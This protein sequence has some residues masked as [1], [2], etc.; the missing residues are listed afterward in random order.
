MSRIKLRNGLQANLPNS[1]MLLGEPLVTT[2]R[3]T[4]HVA[5]SPTVR[6]PIVPA[7]EQ[8]ETLPAVDGAADLLLIHDA[9][10]TGQK[11]KKITLNAF[12]TALNIPVSATDEK[13]SVVS[14][15]AAGY[16]WGTDGSDGILRGSPSI[17]LTKD[18]GN[19]YM[20]MA[21]DVIDGG[22]F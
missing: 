20:A 5:T 14:G 4:L 10:S 22:T 21:V 12:R 9:S 7:I 6:I 13:V 19:A 18:A 17:A 2:D 15:G 1:G 16:L 8:L 3:G 11:E